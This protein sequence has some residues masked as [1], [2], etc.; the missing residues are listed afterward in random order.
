[1]AGSS[2]SR[3]RRWAIRALVLVVLGVLAGVAISHVGELDPLRRRLSEGD[4]RWLAFALAVE[5]VSVTGYALAHRSVLSRFSDRLDWPASLQM[6]L[7]GTVATKLL[8]AGGAGGIA[9]N[10]WALRS[11]GLSARDITRGMTA[12]MVT[13]YS[14]FMLALLVVGLGLA[15][16]ALGSGPRGLTVSVAAFAGAAIALA[17]VS[18]GARGPLLRLESRLADATTLGGR[19]ARRVVTALSLVSL[20]MADARRIVVS[21]PAL[22]GAVLY[23]GGD[24]AVLWLSLHAFGASLPVAVVVL[25]YFA[26]QVANVLPIPGGA[27]AVE[28]GLVGVVLLFGLGSSAAVLGVL[29]FWAVS[30]WAPTL[31]GAVAYLRL[32]RRVALWRTT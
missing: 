7:A 19:L 20:G 25:S 24:I 5:A 1:M 23:W 22:L 3:R 12:L 30:Y 8:G 15:T 14:V 11:L 28:G 27:G 26:A 9:L 21:G 32:R 2:E 4:P 29:G 18:A 10:V 31:P 16:G 6:T 17:V 13:F